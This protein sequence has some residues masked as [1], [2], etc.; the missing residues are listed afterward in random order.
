LRT[1]IIQRRE[2]G[3][4]RQPRLAAD[5]LATRRA[6]RTCRDRSVTGSPRGNLGKLRLECRDPSVERRVGLGRDGGRGGGLAKARLLHRTRRERGI[7]PRVARA[8]DQQER[9]DQGQG[10]A[11]GHGLGGQEKRRNALAPPKKRG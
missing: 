10:T 11:H 2:R 7:V 4:R 1:P 5:R 9:K 6:C 8:A 3:L